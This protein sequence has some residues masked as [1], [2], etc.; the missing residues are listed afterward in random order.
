[1]VEHR[2]GILAL[3]AERDVDAGQQLGAG[4][5]RSHVARGE[6]AEKAQRMLAGAFE[7]RFVYDH[8]PNTMAEISTDKNRLDVTF[9]HR[10]LSEESYWAASIPLELVRISIENSL[11]FGAY[12]RG[13]PSGSARVVTGYATF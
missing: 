5:G 11:C 3:I 12:D 10:F 6:R 4:R 2:G 13:P 1:R 9:V 8:R 7:E